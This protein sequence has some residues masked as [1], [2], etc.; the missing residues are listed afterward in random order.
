MSRAIADFWKTTKSLTCAAACLAVLTPAEVPHKISG[1]IRIEKLASGKV[2]FGPPEI[3]AWA[4]DQVHWYN[5]TNEPHEPGV[6]RSDGTFVAFLEE[7]V[8]AKTSSAVF[9]PFARIDQESRRMVPFSIHY[10]CGLH[11]EEQGVIQVIPTP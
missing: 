4:G 1:R 5:D 6:I 11:P 9:S 10:V 7:P 3:V 8:A 2:R